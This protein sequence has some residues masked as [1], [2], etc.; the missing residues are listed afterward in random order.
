M[1][2][3]C[4]LLPEVRH[5]RGVTVLKR[6]KTEMSRGGGRRRQMQEDGSQL[7]W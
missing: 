7:S 2:E 5:G 6:D 3:Q 1:N 4:L